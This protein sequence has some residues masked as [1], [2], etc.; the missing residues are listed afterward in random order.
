MVR[1]YSKLKVVFA[2][3]VGSRVKL[4]STPAKNFSK[5][6]KKSAQLPLPFR[7]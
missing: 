7:F 3:F 6:A 4:F 2:G 5:G 1:F